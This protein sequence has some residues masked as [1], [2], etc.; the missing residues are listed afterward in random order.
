MGLV[1]SIGS[2]EYGTMRAMLVVLGPD[3]CPVGQ[4]G[5]RANQ[6]TF[7]TS[8]LS[9]QAAGDTPTTPKHPKDSRE[10]FFPAA[11]APTAPDPIPADGLQ[12]PSDT[13]TKP[14][15]VPAATT[16]VITCPPSVSASTPDPSKDPRPPQPPRTEAT[17]SMAS[18][19]PGESRPIHLA[20]RSHFLHGYLAGAGG[21]HGLGRCTSSP[22]G[23]ARPRSLRGDLLVC[24]SAT[25]P[26]STFCAQQSLPLAPAPQSSHP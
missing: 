1:G 9:S 22:S 20:V 5:L 3:R 15:P 8:S 14:R 2:Q 10:N 23:E 18:L 24:S 12:R 13:H 19:S 21:G 26:R 25:H 7:L 6:L 4:C 16:A 17:P 11:V